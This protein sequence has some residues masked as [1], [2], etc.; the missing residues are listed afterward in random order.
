M[1]EKKE[2]LRRDAK[3]RDVKNQT[4]VLE[5]SRDC[6]LCPRLAAYREENR[7]Q[8]PEWYNAPV[9]GFGP[10]EARLLVVGL[11]PGLKGANRTGRP[12]TGDFAGTLLYET[13]IRNGFARGNYG[14]SPDD[15]LE[16]VDCRIV[17]AVRCVPPKNLPDPAEIIA[18]NQF[19]R[20]ELENMTRLEA[21]LALGHVAHLAVLKAYGLGHSAYR[22]RHGAIHALPDG[23]L[24]VD[25]Y[26]VSRYNTQTGRLTPA[27]FEAVVAGLAQRLARAA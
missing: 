9:P 1:A 3:N 14:A 22:F 26:H 18:C 17:N 8:W 24:L 6:P 15:G 25:S 23:L 20:S 7:R 19:L 13:L 10:L 11:A 2:A 16:L 5:P 12:F 21:V 4:A 27:M